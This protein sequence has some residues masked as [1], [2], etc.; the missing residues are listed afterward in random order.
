MVPVLLVR[1]HSVSGEQFNIWGCETCGFQITA[2]APDARN[3]APYYVS[4]DYISHTNTNRGLINQLYQWARLFTLRQ[5]KKLITATTRRQSGNLLEVGAGTGY[6]AETML[7]AGWNVT[8][9][10][11]DSGAREIARQRAG[12]N[13]LPS[14]QLFELPSAHFDV[15]TLWHVLEHVH[16]LSSYLNNFHRLLR[17]EGYL[18]IAVPNY[19]SADAKHYGTHWAA[20]D[21]PRHLYHFSPD[22]MRKLLAS[23]QMEAVSIRP[24]WLDAFYVSLLSEKYAKG[25]N[26]IFS[27]FLQGALSNIRA[28]MKGK[29]TSSLIYIARPIG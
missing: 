23:H 12:L 15:I 11:P 14:D 9:L 13:L 4:E 19:T 6:F 27:G 18:I 25:G 26:N 10:E 20:Y 16:D 1:D 22:S 17:K 2:D 24:M 3:I 7:K 28:L 5:K 8:A 21:V 29:N